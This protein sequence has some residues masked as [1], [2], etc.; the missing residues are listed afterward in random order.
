VGEL[1]CDWRRVN[2]AFTRAKKKLIILGSLSTLENNHLFSIF[3][4]L[5]RDQDWVCELPHLSPP[6]FVPI[7]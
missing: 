2:V 6:L 3:L 5:L 7:S 1:L 4:Q